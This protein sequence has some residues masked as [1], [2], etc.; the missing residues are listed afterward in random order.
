MARLYSGG[1]RLLLV[2]LAAAAPAQPLPLTVVSAAGYQ[3]AITPNSWAAAFGDGLNPST[4]VAGLGADGQFP[5][6]VGGTTVEVN[7]QAARI[8]FVSPG[9][10]NFLVPGG[11][12]TGVATV[13]LRSAASGREFSGTVQV[14]RTA[15][16]LFSL[17]STGQGAGSILN[18]VTN[19]GE[20]FLVETPETRGEDKRTRLAV[21]GTGFRYADQLTAVATP[22]SGGSY[23]LPIE[24][25]GP[26]PDFFGLDQVNV[27]LPAE[28]DGA[29]VVT[30]IVRTPLFS[31]NPV[32]FTMGALQTSEI[33]L[34]GLKLAQATV[35]GG[36]DV[37]G[38]VRLNGRAPVGGAEIALTSDNP[39]VQPPSRVALS[40]GKVEGAFTVATSSPL[41]R[42]TATITA[43]RGPVTK[44]AVLAVEP[45][46]GVLLD[47]IV[48]AEDTVAGG[49]N[50]TGTVRLRE[51]LPAGSLTVN[52]TTSE[53]TAVT[54]SSVTILAGQ[55]SRDFPIQTA[56][57]EAPR[58][59][60]I[61]ASIAANQVSTVLNV[62]PAVTIS[63]RPDSVVGGNP[64]TVDVELGDAA[65]VGGVDV[66]IRSD[67]PAVIPPVTV[68]VAAGQHTSTFFQAT[69]PVVSEAEVTLTALYGGFSGTA[70]LTLKTAGASELESLQLNPTIVVGAA[71][72]GA[73]I[74][75]TGPAPLGGFFVSVSSSDAT[76]SVPPTVIVLAGQTSALFVIH[77]F[78]V[79][80]PVKVTIT[81]QAG[82]VTKTAQLAL[83]TTQA[84]RCPSARPLPARSARASLAQM[85][86]RYS[87]L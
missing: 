48:L 58:P 2:L 61:T 74:T 57:V 43:T 82:G 1:V 62:R 9:Q 19:T 53:A 34:A 12:N 35:L 41:E 54:P 20:P 83:G 30:L 15:P 60:R 5:K 75:L 65:P 69:S 21:Y 56:V 31:S 16:A 24:Y 73:T 40:K 55:I 27:V 18:A 67:N 45:Q 78:A 13:V 32:T 70:V 59:V 52:L 11:T 37:A 49:R 51:P 68:T 4:I 38:R 7:H 17:D 6:E 87:V 80:F 33:R 14:L 36:L 26:T 47:R 42:Q 23:E 71:A 50:I 39:V 76:V 66:D 77:T 85:R 84:A 29:G 10:I 3:P 72:V 63:V 44:T 25:A 79:A 22:A 86:R 28:L 8:Y 81:V 46:N 64:V